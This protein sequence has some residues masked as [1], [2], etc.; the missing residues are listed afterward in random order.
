MESSLPARRE[1]AESAGD[2]FTLR[3]PRA[4]VKEHASGCREERTIVR[5]VPPRFIA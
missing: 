5:A 3:R 4:G 1:V 2:V